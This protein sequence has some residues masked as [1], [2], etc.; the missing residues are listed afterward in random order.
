MTAQEQLTAVME[1]ARAIMSEYDGKALSEEKQKELDGF[2]NQADA[3]RKQIEAGNRFDALDKFHNAPATQVSFGPQVVAD[4]TDRFLDSDEGKFKSFGEQLVA[5]YQ[6]KTSPSSGIDKR[7]AASQKKQIALK[8]LGMSEGVPADGGFLVQ[9]DFSAELFRLAHADGDFL[10]RVRKLPIGA[11]ANGLIMNAI[12]ESDR[13]TGNRWGGI[14]GY[15]LDEAGTK[16][17]THPTLRR[18]ELNLRKLIVLAYATDEL[19]QDTTGL[20]A[21]ITMA[22]SEEIRWLTE[23]AIFRGLGGG[24][25]LGIMGHPCLVTVAAEVGQA[26]NTIV[27]ENVANMYSRR[28][29]PSWPKMVWFINQDT[30]PQLMEMNAAVG[31]GGQ[32]VY[33]PPGGLSASPYG[34]L[35]G[36]PVIATEHNSTLGITGDICLFDLSQYLMIDKGGVQS[37][38]SMHVAF[39]TDQTAFRFVYR[40][41]GQPLWNAQL[42]PANSAITQSPFV[43]LAT[44]P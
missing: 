27:F 33:L 14:R 21:L 15:W 34:F 17:P 8:Q 40:I 38:T 23:E 10:S 43:V 25:P 16:L 4:E 26:A 22:A 28:W 12:A 39:L 2:L 9:Q 30:E 1:S 7:L 36:R 13:S 31:A 11:N 35:Y 6:A 20:G 44:R 41:D 3:L 37:A 24:Q 19:L 32:M 29:A 42:T 18:M 5:V